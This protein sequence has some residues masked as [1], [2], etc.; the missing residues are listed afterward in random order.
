MAEKLHTMAQHGT[1]FAANEVMLQRWAGFLRR[2]RIEAV[3]LGVAVDGL[4]AFLLEPW[5]TL[6][7]GER[8]GK[9]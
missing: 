3:H 8:F 4:R 2:N 5:R 7:S 6:A 1:A 9:E